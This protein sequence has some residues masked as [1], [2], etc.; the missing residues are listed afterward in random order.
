MTVMRLKSS[1]RAAIRAAVT[2]SFGQDA[3]VW[4]FGSRVDDTKRGGDIDLLVKPG[5]SV[6]S[7]QLF[8]R[9]IRLLVQLERILG[10]RKID[11]IVEAPGD[12]RPIVNVA[13]ATGVGL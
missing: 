10:E 2:E 9:K 1:E 6:A 12:I 7:D 3:D 5:C 13:H 8:A 11:V 4:L